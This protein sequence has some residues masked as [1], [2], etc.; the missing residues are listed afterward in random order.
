MRKLLLSSYSPDVVNPKALEE[1]L[2]QREKLIKTVSLSILQGLNGNL[3]T[4]YLFVGQSGIGK[5]FTISVILAR[6]KKTIRAT[7]RLVV[8]SFEQDAWSISSFFDILVALYKSLPRH[9][10]EVL[11]GL[12]E[13]SQ[14][15]WD[16]ELAEVTLIDE[17]HRRSKGHRI[18]VV[19]ESLDEVFEKLGK[20]GQKK[21]RALVQNLKHTCVI[22][23]TAEVFDELTNYNAP[24]YGFFSLIYLEAFTLDQSVDFLQKLARFKGDT[25]VSNA[26]KSSKGLTRI[27]ALHHLAGG[28]PRMFMLF[29]EVISAQSVTTFIHPILRIV[30]ELT[31]V[32][33]ATMGKLS[34]QQ[35]KI[36]QDLAESIRPLTVRAI[37]ERTFISQQTASAQ[38]RDLKNLN[39]LQSTSS[40]RESFYEIKDPL[41]KL[42]IQLRSNRAELVGSLIQFLE[43]WFSP[44]ELQQGILE[45][46]TQEA[47]FHE[48]RKQFKE[49]R[50]TSLKEPIDRRIAKN[51]LHIDLFV[52]SMQA[53]DYDQSLVH[54]KKSIELY[55]SLIVLES[56]RVTP[57]QV[58]RLSSF[59]AEKAKESSSNNMGLL[60]PG[61][62]AVLQGR[63]AK[64]IDYFQRAI[65]IVPTDILAKIS[66]GIVFEQVGRKSE[67]LDICDQ[68]LQIDSNFDHAIILKSEI[69][70]DLG[71][72]DEAL[73]L[74][75]SANANTDLSYLRAS[76]LFAKGD[77]KA[78][79]DYVESIPDSSPFS[80]LFRF[81]RSRILFKQ[82]KLLEAFRIAKSLVRVNEVEDQ[83]WALIAQILHSWGKEKH[84]V[85]AA[86][87]SLAINPTQISALWAKSLALVELQQYEQAISVFKTA[88]KHVQHPALSF[89]H[90][91][92]LAQI[93]HFEEAL[94]VLEAMPSS[95]TND[96]D[97]SFLT[98]LCLFKLKRFEEAEPQLRLTIETKPNHRPAVKMLSCI[99]FIRAKFQEV[100]KLVESV[101]PDSQLIFLKAGS[102]LELNNK[103]LALQI[104]QNYE[105]TSK[106]AGLL[107][108]KGILLVSVERL[109]EAYE[110]FY[111]AL[112]I[113]QN[114][115][116]ALANLVLISAEL[117]RLTHIPEW[118]RLIAQREEHQTDFLKALIEKLLGQNS[119]EGEVLLSMLR[120][121]SCP[122]WILHVGES[123]FHLIHNRSEQALMF[124][125]RVNAENDLRIAER[126]EIGLGFLGVF[127]QKP[128]QAI[129][130][131]VLLLLTK[132]IGPQT[133]GAALL[134]F[135]IQQLT[136]PES[137]KTSLSPMLARL[138]E[139]AI[140]DDISQ[141]INLCELALAFSKNKDERIFAQVSAEE[142]SLLDPLIVGRKEPQ[143]IL[144]VF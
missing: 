37:S 16:I 50:R 44:I 4:H 75:D 118:L 132:S 49:R 108:M 124:L 57:Q 71:R 98:G 40:G 10:E 84:A 91:T 113:S 89:N 96:P 125:S 23:S 97:F 52:K 61:Y 25:K 122:D 46:G 127:A 66:L 35:R 102:Y 42:N 29:Y 9:S 41:F 116:V 7:S 140:S 137:N 24:F 15:K 138:A 56:H 3:Q 72:H 63:Y 54:L 26:L 20:S 48:M 94:T 109:E 33:Q 19:I 13:A 43:A 141:S 53:G 92:T 39:I 51:E 88:E 1:I 120:Q 77:D 99:Q 80:G 45:L 14:H 22:A 17:I 100:I 74:I 128:S 144:E 139:S 106:D 112:S 114:R 82:G 79:L 67:A 130:N 60:L 142:R 27:K 12:A 30:D 121:F 126:M 76:I 36:V 11:K 95:E 34:P 28:N 59:V 8:C 62:V 18:V 55:P 101:P 32:Y 2:V 6:L 133:F 123:I 86:D 117:N 81:I 93:G 21:F 104:L 58:D 38:L 110:S 115:P 119:R 65:S 68:I 90:A 73:M 107:E 134:R 136:D 131:E 47:M 111:H 5:T 85:A 31:P 83:S 87:K 78:T 103:D 69:L 129:I 105:G 70:S 64:A 143:I 135:F